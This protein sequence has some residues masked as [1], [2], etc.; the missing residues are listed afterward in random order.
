MNLKTMQNLAVRFPDCL[1]VHRDI[2]ELIKESDAQFLLMRGFKD[3]SYGNDECPSFSHSKDWGNDEVPCIY[4]MDT[5]DDDGHRISG[6]ILWSIISHG[7][8][9]HENVI[10]KTGALACDAYLDAFVPDYFKNKEAK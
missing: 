1:G 3:V 2:K 9:P 7:D 4:A 5:I 10:F 6:E 8:N